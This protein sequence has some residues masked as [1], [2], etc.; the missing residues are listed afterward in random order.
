MFAEVKTL[1]AE[2]VELLAP[3][4][5]DDKT[6]HSRRDVIKRLGEIGHESAVVSLAAVASDHEW[7]WTVL[8]RR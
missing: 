5:R 3:L 4:L 7:G 1:G 6:R 8:A 2:A